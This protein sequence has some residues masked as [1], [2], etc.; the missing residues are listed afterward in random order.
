M[1]F[2]P[3]RKTPLEASEFLGQLYLDISQCNP[4]SLAQFL[5][6]G[7]STFDVLFSND[8][9]D[10]QNQLLNFTSKCQDYTKINGPITLHLAIG[11]ITCHEHP[12]TLPVFLAP[13]TITKEKWQLSDRFVINEYVKKL[14]PAINPVVVRE[15]KAIEKMLHSNSLTQSSLAIADLGKKCLPG[16]S[17]KHK[18]VIGNFYN[19]D[20]YT[21]QDAKGII[22]QNPGFNLSNIETF[23]VGFGEDKAQILFTKLQKLLLSGQ[24]VSLVIH[25]PHVLER[26]REMIRRANFETKVDFKPADLQNSELKKINNNDSKD[27]GK[28]NKD[29]LIHALKNDIESSWRD[30]GVSID[31]DEQ[32]L[33]R[34]AQRSINS[35]Y[36]INPDF[37]VSAIECIEK[38]KKLQKRSDFIYNDLEHKSFELGVPVAKEIIKDLP[39][40]T[41]LLMQ[42]MNLGLLNPKAISSP[43]YNA[44]VSSTGTAGDTKVRVLRIIQAIERLQHRL[45]NAGLS[46]LNSLAKT[47]SALAITQKISHILTFFEWAVFESTNEQELHD[48]ANQS[49]ISFTDRARL[50]KEVKKYALKNI[51]IANP[52]AI[53]TEVLDVK[54]HFVETFGSTQVAI[55]QELLEIQDDFAEIMQDVNR[56][57]VVVKETA[58]Y[59]DLFTADFDKLLHYFNTLEKHLSDLD[60]LPDRTLILKKLKLKGLGSFLDYLQPLNL[61]TNEASTLL[62]YVTYQCILKYIGLPDF[63]INDTFN[64]YSH[65]HEKRLKAVLN[66]NTP[67]GVISLP[68]YFIK[69]VD[70]TQIKY[71]QN[72]IDKFDMLLVDDLTSF[73]KAEITVLSAMTRQLLAGVNSL[74]KFTNA[75]ITNPILAGFLHHLGVE[76]GKS[77]ATK[78]SKIKVVRLPEEELKQAVSARVKNAEVSSTGLNRAN[79]ENLYTNLFYV[80]QVNVKSNEDHSKTKQDIEKIKLIDLANLSADDMFDFKTDTYILYISNLSH[81]RSKIPARN[82]LKYLTG[83]VGNFEL[84]IPAKIPFNSNFELY[85]RLADFLESQSGIKSLINSSNKNKDFLINSIESKLR[86]KNY[87]TASNVQGLICDDDKTMGRKI[88]LVI[89]DK[90]ALLINDETVSSQDFFQ[91]VKALKHGGWQVVLASSLD[92]FY[93]EEEVL[94][95]IEQAL[96][97]S[98]N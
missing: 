39:E 62:E 73:T 83:F 69:S 77:W 8:K 19:D 61:S 24:K 12:Y 13:I 40:T 74:S 82:L 6:R 4:Q 1:K 72:K 31:Q 42:G 65:N 45:E 20:Y 96:S 54:Q 63:S 53:F 60:I 46:T 89:E 52:Q 86:G 51:R 5:A 95:D 76:V 33:L 70:L 49:R 92:L 34:L 80:D 91:G 68:K 25:N 71:K 48:L 87:K 21:M 75:N 18:K 37:G 79:G 67:K 3:R 32:T 90:I 41:A 30:L 22:K 81:I 11:F 43:W 59:F 78:N 26:L 16:F 94:K 55:K 84:Y 14:F 17:I 93:R 10:A 64:N 15:L 85:V 56:L 9:K 97:A 44:T 27:A 50:K 29:P 23:N 35:L 47:D 98:S 58:D 88:N 28:T 36:E 66:A 2:S 38:I 57:K 7:E